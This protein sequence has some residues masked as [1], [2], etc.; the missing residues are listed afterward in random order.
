MEKSEAR[1]IA[2]LESPALETERTNWWIRDRMRFEGEDLIFAGQ[3]VEDLAKRHDGRVMMY[4]GQRIRSQ[5]ALLKG[6]L[7]R[8][9][10]PNRLY[11]AV[12]AN[13]FGGIL[14]AVRDTGVVGIDCCSPGEVRLALSAGFAPEEI[15]FTG[16]SV[17]EEDI[18]FLVD[19]PIRI[20]VN[21]I[22]MIHKIGWY[23]NGRAIGLRLN[24]QLGVGASPGLTYAGPQ[25]T[26]F[27]I[28]PD[29]IEEAVRLADSYGLVIEG[30][31]M[32]VGSGWLREGTPRFLA[33]MERMV[34]LAAGIG[35]P[36]K[37]V[38]VGGGLGV[39]HGP[40][41]KP[42]DL[43]T[44][45]HGVATTVRRY[46]GADVEICCEPG[47]FLVNDCAVIAATVTEVEEKGGLLFVGLNIGFNA[48]PQAAHYG[49]V[50]ELVHAHRGPTPSDA[51]CHVVTGNINEVIDVFNPA[52]PLPN[53]KEGD[54][55]AILNVGGYSSSMRSAHCLRDLPVEIML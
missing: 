48:N 38:N 10:Q 31:H 25:A 28:Y 55:L 2:T 27:G 46:L 1:L 6:A 15:S 32:H 21:S 9:G 8:T 43:D 53:V 41:D 44:Y 50:P 33:A 45:A 39:V 52:A 13:R 18:E 12:K 11:Y 34:E 24:P 20:N 7:N 29:R 14:G 16:C 26:K 5:I 19:L 3:R 54:V 49:F 40:D 22:S 30:V 47:D 37:Y 23:G 4:D 17:S 35:K 42:V 36:L 51:R